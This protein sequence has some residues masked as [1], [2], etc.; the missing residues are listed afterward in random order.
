M[1]HLL[2]PPLFALAL[3]TP[4]AAQEDNG[5]SLMEEGAQL[6]LRG[7]MTEMEPAIDELEQFAEELGPAMRGM[8]AELRP[9]VRDILAAIDDIEFYDSIEVL[10]NGDILIRRSA[11][12]PPFGMTDDML[13]GME[14]DDIDAPEI[15][16]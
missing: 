15:E 13:R 8:A 2:I 6:F 1:K 3:T 16:L 12:A 7:L 14:E 11:D 4:V 10:E 9:L 5:L